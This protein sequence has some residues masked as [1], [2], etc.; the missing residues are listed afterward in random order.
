MGA[1]KLFHILCQRIKNCWAISLAPGNTFKLKMAPLENS[2]AAPSDVKDTSQCIPAILQAAV[3]IRQMETYVHAV[4]VCYRQWQCYPW[5]RNP[6]W[7][8]KCFHRRAMQY[9]SAI[10]EHYKKQT[11]EV[12]HTAGSMRLQ[13]GGWWTQAGMRVCLVI[14]TFTLGNP[15]HCKV[16]I[17]THRLDWCFQKGGRKHL[18]MVRL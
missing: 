7:F 13:T 5:E 2:L 15:D 4:L 18:W 6:N 17:S 8:K 9:H 11:A 3:Y 1:E 10:K 12:T 16:F 14:Y